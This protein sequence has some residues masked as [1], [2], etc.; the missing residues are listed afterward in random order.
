MVSRRWCFT[1]NNYSP[2]DE[3]NIHQ[4]DTKY[5]VYGRE[6]GDSGTPHL[7]GFVTFS[8]PYRLSGV[9]KL[10][11]TAH[12]EITKASS[13]EASDYCKKGSQS[14]SEWDD[15][16]ISG[17]TFGEN[18][19]V[20]ER[21]IP[22]FPG[23]RSD[24]DDIA[25]AAKAGATLR[26]LSDLAPATY[27]RNYRG[28]AHY[29]ALHS[30]AYGHHDVRG[31]WFYGAPGTGKSHAARAMYP[32][33]YLKPQNKWFDGYSGEAVIILDDLD[34]GG[35]CLGHHLKIWLD[36]YPCTAETKGGSI[37]LQHRVFII[38]SNYT[39]ADV[40]GR[41]DDDK[42]NGEDQM[43]AAITR[44]IQFF[45]FSKV[46]I[47]PCNNQTSPGDWVPDV[48]PVLPN[49]F[50]DDTSIDTSLNPIVS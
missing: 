31:V 25:A 45:S 18:A 46:F 28:I 40:F 43:V 20:F 9:K 15:F 22:P 8:K 14:K 24:L 10:H 2:L 41:R 33:A 30:S 17:S 44:R 38:T 50:Y 39:P 27:I 34:F 48:D 26:E 42:D 23:Q 49:G 6:V 7:Q 21:G 3:V 11:S 5:L 12:W 1:V 4:W 37:D 16:N 29:K 47:P 13:K 35:K 36:K 32:N 19:D